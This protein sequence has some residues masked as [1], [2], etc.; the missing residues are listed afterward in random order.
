MEKRCPKSADELQS[1]APGAYKCPGCGGMFIP[2]A[3]APFVTEASGSSSVDYDAQ[4]GRCPVD[5]TIMSRAEIVIAEQRSIHL[6]RCSSCRGVWF[7]SGEWSL[8]ATQKLLD[9]LDEFWTTE[10]RTRQRRQQNAREYENRQREEFGPELFAELQSI[11]A[12]LQ[13]HERRSQALAFLREA[14]EV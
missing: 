8:L 2:S 10:W 13:G 12:K 7:D 3:A 14:S 4:A 9:N 1:I 11:A 5:G 6:E